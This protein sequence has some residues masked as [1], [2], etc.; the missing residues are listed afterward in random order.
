MV[1]CKATYLRSRKKRAGDGS[2]RGMH[3][4]R[5]ENRPLREVNKDRAENRPLRGLCVDIKSCF[6]YS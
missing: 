6:R 5:A 3:K 4:E 1:A 2:L